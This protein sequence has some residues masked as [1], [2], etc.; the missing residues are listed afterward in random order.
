MRTLR[1]NVVVRIE[2]LGERVVI[3]RH[4]RTPRHVAVH[5]RAGA[6]VITAAGG[7]SVGDEAMYQAFTRHAPKPVRVLHRGDDDLLVPAKDLGAEGVV[8]KDL[9]YGRGIRSHLRAVSE[10]ARLVDVVAACGIVGADMM[11]G[12]YNDRAAA[13][14]FRLAEIAARLGADSRVL[15]FSWVDK[16]SPIAKRALRRTSAQVSLLARD[17]V[18]ASRLRRDGGKNVHEVADLAFLTE[19]NEEPADSSAQQWIEAQHGAGREVVLVN[20][21]PRIAVKYPGQDEAYKKLVS[22]LVSAGYSCLALPHDSRHG[23]NSETAYLQKLLEDW[24]DS[25]H[26]FIAG[27]VVLPG[28]VSRLAAQC[29]L[30]VSGR[31][32]LVILAAVGGTPSVGLEYQDKF[33]GL[34]EYLGFDLRVKAGDVRTELLEAT[35][36]ALSTREELRAQLQSALPR[37][38]QFA[39]RNIPE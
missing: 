21:N 22:T 11:D 24:S 6:I 3:A 17:P 12:I 14:R 9:V 38:K 35:L 2:E 31:M 1:R 4:E 29:A 23:A 39:G 27:D 28:E 16:P 33:E 30:A 37:V 20:A 36:S 10:F 13:R 15:G 7:G 19:V 8:L 18:S 26:V 5:E 32:H 34:Y 25:E